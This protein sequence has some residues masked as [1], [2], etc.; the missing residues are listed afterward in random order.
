MEREPLVRFPVLCPTCASEM[1]TAVPVKAVAA[2]LINGGTVR[3]HATCHDKW[4]DATAIE[5]QQI[6]EYLAATS[7]NA[8]SQGPRLAVLP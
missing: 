2:A 1:L 5:L 3:L 8:P 7:V 6:R 4:W